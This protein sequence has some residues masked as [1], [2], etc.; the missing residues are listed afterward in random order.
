M[1]RTQ[2]INLNENSKEEEE[3]GQQQVQEKEEKEEEEDEEEEEEELGISSSQELD[4]LT[5]ATDSLIFGECSEVLKYW[6]SVLDFKGKFLQGQDSQALQLVEAIELTSSHPNFKSRAK[7]AESYFF[8]SYKSLSASP[9]PTSAMK[10]FKMG[11]T[12]LRETLQKSFLREYRLLRKLNRLKNRTAEKKNEVVQE[13]LTQELLEETQL[14]LGEKDR[15][16]LELEQGAL[17]KKKEFVV[18]KERH[19]E[20]IRKLREEYTE[21]VSKLQ[22]Q[23]FSSIEQGDDLRAELLKKDSELDQFRKERDSSKTEEK[24]T[25]LLKKVEE[26]QEQIDLLQETHSRDTDALQ[27]LESQS[28]SFQEQLRLKESEGLRLLDSLSKTEALLKESKESQVQLKQEQ[29]SL[30][31]ENLSLLE[32][33]QVIEKSNEDLS[34]SKQLLSLKE[35]LSSLTKD[36]LSSKSKAQSLEKQLSQSQLLVHKLEDDL[37]SNLNLF[38]S[39]K[40]EAKFDLKSLLDANSTANPNPKGL[41]TSSMHSMPLSQLTLNESEGNL[42]KVL[43]EQRE[44]YKAKILSLEAS[45]KALQ[46]DVSKTT[47][48]KKNLLSENQSLAEKIR[49]TRDYSSQMQKPSAVKVDLKE[50]DSPFDQ[51][52]KR[53]NKRKMEALSAPERFALNSMSFLLKNKYTRLFLLFY[54]I[55]LHG[56]VFFSVSHAAHHDDRYAPL[57]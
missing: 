22:A 41:D 57:K 24:V 15:K 35:E 56:V 6:D 52:H 55:L 14:S 8:S 28:L 17:E 36:Y 10:N 26:L 1:D 53:E 47:K 16:L 40:S 32:Q 29:E 9:D 11:Y 44:R 18:E 51:F 23:W 21:N 45:N 7:T 33:R 27:N 2:E 38:S 12:F 13:N 4:S 3:E 49:Y 48:E 54:T 30:R 20:E 25:E 42:M 34:S 5:Q 19:Q 39:Q 37:E 31:E 43:V 50:Y 46:E